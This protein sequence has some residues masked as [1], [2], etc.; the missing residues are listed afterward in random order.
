MAALLRVPIIRFPRRIGSELRGISKL[1][2]LTKWQG[3]FL[4]ASTSCKGEEA[5]G[6]TPPSFLQHRDGVEVNWKL[7]QQQLGSRSK[8]HY[9]WLRDNCMCPQCFH[10]ETSQRLVNALQVPLDV[11][12]SR[13][14][15]TTKSNALRVEWKDGHI[16]EYSM[17][18]LRKNSYE[19]E[20]DGNHPAPRFESDRDDT[21]DNISVWGKE[22]ASNPPLVEFA[23]VM[24]DDRE[25]LECLKLVKKYGFCFIHGTPV[26]VEESHKLMS[27][28]FGVIRNT[29]YGPFWEFTSTME[30][31][32][33][34]VPFIV[35]NAICKHFLGRL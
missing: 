21:N 7:T 18:W 24:Q 15:F 5:V 20:R 9:V 17:A 26:S 34:Y 3:R 29:F 6:N 22:I 4:A 12:P 8:F 27:S 25:C 16:S 19:H 2:L 10:P 14:E 1:P 30:S 23:K 13:V 28:M 31:S 33:R 35:K 32:T 11:S